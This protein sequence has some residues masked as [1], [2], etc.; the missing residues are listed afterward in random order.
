MTKRRQVGLGELCRAMLWLGLTG[1]GGW[2]AYY[3]DGF[4]E[5]RHWLTHEEY[6]EGLA[7]TNLVPGPTFTNFAVFASQRLVGWIAVPLV[8]VLVLLPGAVGMLLLTVWF[9]SGV[10][11][12]PA[13]AEGLKGLSAAAAA[14][15]VV[16]VVRLLRA[17][18]VNRTG[19]IVAAIAIVAIGALGLSL[20]VV[21]PPLALLAIWLER[22]RPASK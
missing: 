3:H 10:S 2:P 4:V 12:S 21:A 14:L 9:Q 22:P 11:T 5:E 15:V 6:L 7:I 8:L 17:R 16:T 20:I 1:L 13:V 19:L 18:A